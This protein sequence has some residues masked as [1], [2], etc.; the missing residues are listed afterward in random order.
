MQ[1]QLLKN[2]IKF[3]NIYWLKNS[4]YVYDFLKSNYNQSNFKKK[5]ITP[6][7]IKLSSQYREK[8][9]DELIIPKHLF[10]N[11]VEKIDWLSC[12]HFL[13]TLNKTHYNKKNLFSY[14]NKIPKDI[15]LYTKKAWI[16][17]YAILIRKIISKKNSQSENKIFGERPKINLILTHDIDVTKNTINFFLKQIIFILL[18]SIKYIFKLKIKSAIKQIARIYFLIFEQDYIK[19]IKKMIKKEKILK[20][21]KI[22]FINSNTNKSKNWFSI[23]N[24][25]NPNYSLEELFFLK[26][27]IDKRN[28]EIGIHPS[29][30]TFNSIKL[31][32]KE[33]KHVEEFFKQKI[34][35]SRQHWLKF[36]KNK[37]SSVLKKCNI[38]NDFTFG[39]NDLTCF[40]GSLSLIFKEKGINR[41][42]MIMMDSHLYDY[43]LMDYNSIKS[44]I[45]NVIDEIFFV[46]GVASINWHPHTISQSYGWDK[47][48]YYLIKQI[49][50]NEKYLQK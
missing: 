21:K 29:I 15:L 26:E 45:K 41:I 34:I 5:D 49:K 1:E 28:F 12:I 31:M 48:Y 10:K 22:Y 42:P 30:Q 50:K 13:I 4:R 2:Y 38:I 44:S 32:K 11:D 39:F 25:I 16:N 27:Y 18:N 14:S 40:R 24:L 46:G 43:S 19:Y 8:K 23:K 9:F 6:V 17:R 7:K 37:T 20:C 47:G 3:L 33:K 36:E 35:N